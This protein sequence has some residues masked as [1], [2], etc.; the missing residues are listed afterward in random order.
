MAFRLSKRAYRSKQTTKIYQNS[1]EGPTKPTVRTSLI[2][3]IR[4]K[5]TLNYFQDFR[6]FRGLN[7][8]QSS[9]T[10]R[11]TTMINC[12]FSSRPD[13]CTVR[14]SL[15]ISSDGGYPTDLQEEF[16]TICFE[17]WYSTL[18]FG[19]QHRSV[20]GDQYHQGYQEL[21]KLHEISRI[22]LSFPYGIDWL[23]DAVRVLIPNFSTLCV[24][25]TYKHLL[26]ARKLSVG[27]L[28]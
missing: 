8:I 6:G 27:Q 15:S 11:A 28:F 26:K 20:G 17:T 2:C 3:E 5:Q 22:A 24:M 19:C 12:T 18:C 9:R 13:G 1:P 23:L 14:E 16:N 4:T 7:Q 25:T 21:Q 10:M